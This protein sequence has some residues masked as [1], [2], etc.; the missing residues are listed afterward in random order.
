MNGI[1]PAHDVFPM[2]GLYEKG[3]G[4]SGSIKAKNFVIGR[5]T[6]VIIILAW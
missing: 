2:V 6:T 5:K 3:D 1:Q 4:L